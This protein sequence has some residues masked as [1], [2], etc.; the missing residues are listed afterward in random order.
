MMKSNYFCD[1]CE[2][3]IGDLYGPLFVN[4]ASSTEPSVSAN[5]EVCGYECLIKYL[6]KVSRTTK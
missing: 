5:L 2:K 4:I 1:Y 6:Q 3:K